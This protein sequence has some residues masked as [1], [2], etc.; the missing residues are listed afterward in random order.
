M[1]V[2]DEIIPV[3]GMI[4]FFRTEARKRE[5]PGL[6]LG[7]RFYL[8][9]SQHTAVIRPVIDAWLNVGNQNLVNHAYLPYIFS[10]IIHSARYQVLFK[11]M[12]T[13]IKIL[14]HRSLQP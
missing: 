14:K 11:L 7:S 5:V 4:R 9:V 6:I 3:Q 13:T 2:Y 12:R 8:I 1:H 10:R